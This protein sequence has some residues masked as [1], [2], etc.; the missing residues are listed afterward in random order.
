[1]PAQPAPTVGG[2]ET[3]FEAI[4]A[5]LREGGYS[6]RHGAL[7]EALAASLGV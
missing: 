5:D 2:D 7:P 3:L 6:V 4:A 1:M